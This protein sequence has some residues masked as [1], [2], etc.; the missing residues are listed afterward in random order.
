VKKL[1]LLGV[2]LVKSNTDAERRVRTKSFLG[3]GLKF[4][5][6]VS[7]W[8]LFMLRKPRFNLGLQSSN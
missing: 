8:T 5:Q 1:T 2:R 6:K 7:R 4:D 3:G